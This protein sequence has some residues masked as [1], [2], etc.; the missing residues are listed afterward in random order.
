MTE[1]NKHWAS[2]GGSVVQRLTYFKEV[3]FL[4]G[5][6]PPQ[7]GE[8]F[9]LF[10]VIGSAMET[11]LLR[12]SSDAAKGPGFVKFQLDWIYQTNRLFW[13]LRGVRVPEVPLVGSLHTIPLFLISV[14][15][16]RQCRVCSSRSTRVQLSAVV[17]D[18][19]FCCP[20]ILVIFLALFIVLICSLL[21]PC[22]ILLSFNLQGIVWRPHQNMILFYCFKC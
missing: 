15:S 10:D 5:R 13:L 8:L 7:R 6:S 17:L 19:L 11:P 9:T 4:N 2:H 1:S 12:P 3:I 20:L 22:V 16:L 14:S 18:E 21:I